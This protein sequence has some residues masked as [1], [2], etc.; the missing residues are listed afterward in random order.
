MAKLRIRHHTG[1][2]KEYIL[3]SDSVLIGKN[4]RSKQIKNDLAFDDETVSRRHARIYFENNHYYIEDLGSRNHTYVNDERIKRARLRGQD[5][6]RIGFTSIV[7]ESDTRDQTITSATINKVSPDAGNTV[8]LNYL[9][10]QRINEQFAKTTSLQDIIGWLI[11][12]ACHSTGN[13]SGL[14]EVY[15]HE[16]ELYQAEYGSPG[17]N[18]LQPLFNR[19]KS[20]K[21]ILHIHPEE[22]EEAFESIVEDRSVICIPIVNKNDLLGIIYIED[23][24]NKQFSRQDIRLISDIANHTAAGLERMILN[25]RVRKEKMARQNMEDFLKSLQKNE[26]TNRALLNAIPD[27][28]MHLQQDGTVLSCKMPKNTMPL[29]GED[30]PGKKLEEFLPESIKEETL[31]YIEQALYVGT[32]Q[33]FEFQLKLDKKVRYY[34]NRI[35]ACGHSEVLSIIRDITDRVEA[36]RMQ[37]DL[38]AELQDALHKIKTLKGLIPICSSCKKI[39]DDQGS[40]KQLELYIQEHSEAEFSHGICEECIK[41]LY[42]DFAKKQ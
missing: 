34:E 25:Q 10:L 37:A 31:S 29:F 2:E 12:L 27:L 32:I 8:D 33:V 4:D 38:I 5:H 36:E 1:E 19:V 9:I 17:I 14:I 13:E 41:V 6:I 15:D 11:K 7:F 28:M 16:Q 30:I 22:T 3:S 35:M 18:D 21:E 39:R 24:S 26:H 23:K 42:P 20:S 40:W